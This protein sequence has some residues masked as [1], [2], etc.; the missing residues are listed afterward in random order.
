MIHHYSVII[1]HQITTQKSPALPALRRLSAGSPCLHL[2]RGAIHRGDAIEGFQ[3]FGRVLLERSRVTP[4]KPYIN[5]LT[6][7]KIYRKP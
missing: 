5:G 2:A 7:G 3:C 4:G 1:H 6:E